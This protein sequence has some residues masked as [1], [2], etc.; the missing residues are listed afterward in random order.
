MNQHQFREHFHDLRAQESRTRRRFLLDES[1]FFPILNEDTPSTAFDRHYLYHPAW[2]CRILR[3][4]A[5]ALHYDFSSVLSFAAAISAWVPTVFCDIRPADIR[6]DGLS[7][8]REDLTKISLPDDSVE[9]LSCMHA[10]EHVGLGRYGDDI[11]YDGD[12]KAVREIQRITSRGGNILF[13]VPVGRVAAIQF[14]AHRIYTWQSVLDLFAGGFELVESALIPD[15]QELG[16]VG[17]PD[18]DLLARQ[19]YAC[20]CF[21]FRK[22]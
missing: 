8:R 7:V 2:A 14:N 22:L 18:A 1:I 19:T 6:L 21:W 4:I 9:S 3:R 12:I 16:L 15:Q 20:G 13:V 11:D 17:A 10:V 5:P